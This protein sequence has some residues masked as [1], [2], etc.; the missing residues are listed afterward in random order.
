MS[1]DQ[2]TTREM[3]MPKNNSNKIKSIKREEL[4]KY[5]E[6]HKFT[7]KMSHYLK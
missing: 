6:K 4:N 2:K 7:Y 5:C 1:Y 3:L